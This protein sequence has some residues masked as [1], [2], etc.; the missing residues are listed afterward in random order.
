MKKFSE[1]SSMP[2]HSTKRLILTA[3][4]SC[5]LLVGCAK[6]VET[7]TS[8]AENKPTVAQEKPI[9]ATQTTANNQLSQ[10]DKLLNLLEEN[11]LN[12]EF[13]QN[14]IAQNNAFFVKKVPSS[15]QACMHDNFN[16]NNFKQLHHQA[17]TQYISKLS[18]QEKKDLLTF[19]T[20]LTGDKS[21]KE[22]SKDIVNDGQIKSFE[23][24][25]HFHPNTVKLLLDPHYEMLRG[26]L[27]I[28]TATPQGINRQ[29][30]MMT[31]FLYAKYTANNCGT[32]LQK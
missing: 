14:V 3:L 32:D 9:V 19:L 7:S 30:F 20:P 17:L 1:G 18:N 28:P 24:S 10:N 29:S 6:T 31:L 13:L 4:T 27:F 11:T 23:K 16:F 22:F 5:F 12:D 2:T 25:K 26:V 15:Y 8:V 21:F